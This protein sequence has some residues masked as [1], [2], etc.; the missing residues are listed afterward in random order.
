MSEIVQVSTHSDSA[1]AILLIGSEV[2]PLSNTVAFQCQFRHQIPQPACTAWYAICNA[3]KLTIRTR[4]VGFVGSATM[5]LVCHARQSAKTR[6]FSPYYAL[7]Q[8]IS[9]GK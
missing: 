7:R 9:V 1:Q 2:Y 8:V 5:L 6:F 3:T 4:L